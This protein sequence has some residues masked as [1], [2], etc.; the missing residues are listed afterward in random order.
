MTLPALARGRAPSS[1]EHFEL[2]GLAGLKDG[3]HAEALFDQGHETRDLGLV[4]VSRGAVD[5]FDLH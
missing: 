3:F 5:D 4:V 2:S 1:R